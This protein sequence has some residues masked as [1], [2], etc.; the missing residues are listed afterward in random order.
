MGEGDQA[1]QH[2]AR[3]KY[4]LRQGHLLQEALGGDEAEA[5]VVDGGG[6]HGPDREPDGEMGQIDREVDLEYLAIDQAQGADLYGH[7]DRQPERAEGG[8]AIALADILPAQMEDQP[9]M[10]A[11]IDQI[12]P[13]QPVIALAGGKQN[14]V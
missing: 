4:P 13:R 3:R 1:A 8:A 12:M 9:P 11:R 2:D 7:A 10:P 14:R 6:K 5:A